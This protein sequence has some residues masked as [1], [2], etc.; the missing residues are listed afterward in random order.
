MALQG[1][2]LGSK[3]SESARVAPAEQPHLLLHSGKG[4]RLS[5]GFIH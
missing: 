3:R 5:A 1:A 4:L 2:C